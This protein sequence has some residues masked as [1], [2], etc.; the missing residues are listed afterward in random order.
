MAVAVRMA[1]VK[2]G[3]R[4]FEF[5]GMIMG[6]ETFYIRSLT[7]QNTIMA[8]VALIMIAL[9]V[10]CFLKKQTMHAIAVILWMG[11]FVWFFNGPFWGFSAV[12]ISPQ[13]IE[14]HYGFLSVFKPKHLPADTYWKIQDYRGGIRRLKQ[15]HYFV[16]DDDIESLR[17]RGADKLKTLESIG[18][19]IDRINGKSMGER[20][21]LF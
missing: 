14:P 12:T 3:A 11:F 18:A 5:K 2:S 6:A 19:S 4:H 21:K 1:A 9:L 17:V 20:V 10:R 16:L 8:I 13:G 15:L 7:V